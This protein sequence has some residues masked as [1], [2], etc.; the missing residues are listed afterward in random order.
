MMRYK[1]A[2]RQAFFVEGLCYNQPMC[3]FAAYAVVK[4]HV[5]VLNFWGKCL[6]LLLPAQVTA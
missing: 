3:V 2:T 6:I 1:P 5:A 4:L